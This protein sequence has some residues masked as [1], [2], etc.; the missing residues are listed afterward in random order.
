MKTRLFFT[1]TSI[2]A[3]IGAATMGRDM[4]LPEVAAVSVLIFAAPSYLA[5]VRILGIRKGVLVLAVLG[6]FAITIESIALATGLPYGE[7]TY[8]GGLGTPLPGG[9]PWTVAFAWPP[10]LIGSYAAS[11]FIG[12]KNRLRIPLAILLLVAAD[13]VLDPGAVGM[14]YWS[15]ASGGIWYNVPLSNYG[16]WIL[17]GIIGVLLLRLTAGALPPKKNLTASYLYSVSFWTGVSATFGFWVPFLCG[18]LLTALLLPLRLVR[19]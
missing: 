3:G 18:L 8:T 14:G 7:F 5:L 15:Y 13:L 9:V 19:W 16:G 10:L 1:L 6:L 2:F 17:S 11:G 12:T 4:T